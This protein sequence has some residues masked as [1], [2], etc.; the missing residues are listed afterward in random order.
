MSNARPLGC[1]G[2]CQPRKGLGPVLL[3]ILPALHKPCPGLMAT[4]FWVND[5]CRFQRRKS[6]QPQPGLFLDWVAEHPRLHLLGV[7]R[8]FVNPAGN[9]ILHADMWTVSTQELQEKLFCFQ[10]LL[11]AFLVEPAPSEQVLC[12]GVGEVCTRRE[13]QDH[14]P[15]HFQQFQRVNLQMPLWMPSGAR[16]YI[17]AVC[18]MPQRPERLADLL[19]FFASNQY[20]HSFAASWSPRRAR[21]MSSIGFLPLPLVRTGPAP[22]FT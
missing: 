10:A 17:A 11:V 8:H 15:S 9:R 19:R 14:I 7:R 18:L 1:H 12:S 5:I 3:P 16:L 22:A 4:A 2:F 6:F 20:S 21:W 13:R